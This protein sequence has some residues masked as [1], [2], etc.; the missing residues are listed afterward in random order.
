MKDPSRW[1]GKY[2]RM[3]YIC[4]VHV[5]GYAKCTLTKTENSDVS[6]IRKHLHEMAKTKDHLSHKRTQLEMSKQLN[7]ELLA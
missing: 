7:K 4:I 1:L 6:Q 5:E 3:S 2:A